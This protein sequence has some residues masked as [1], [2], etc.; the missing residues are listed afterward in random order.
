ML[1][2][3]VLKQGTDGLYRP[4][5]KTWEED[6]GALIKVRT[7]FMPDGLRKRTATP[8]SGPGGKAA[9]AGGSTG[10][11]SE[12]QAAS[13]GAGWK[14]LTLRSRILDTQLV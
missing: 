6:E 8:Q 13:L 1:P 2:H 12:Q 7:Q 3:R 14:L 10:N 9:S 11:P 4:S 5:H